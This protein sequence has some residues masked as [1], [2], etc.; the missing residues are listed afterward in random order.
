VNEQ[1]T[2][3]L[4]QPA[5]QAPEAVASW[6]NA[7]TGGPAL[8]RRKDDHTPRTPSAV[9]RRERFARHHPEIPITARREGTSL[10]FE[11]AEPGKEAELYNDPDAMMNDLEARYP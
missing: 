11:V 8:P 10:V 9:V 1:Q 5:P 2:R 7:G 4:K 3:K 6:G